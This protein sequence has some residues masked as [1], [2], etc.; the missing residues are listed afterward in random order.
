ME[1][2]RHSKRDQAESEDETLML[3]K[4]IEERKRMQSEV[5]RIHRQLMDASR[6]AGQAEV[7]T[8]VLH[9][10]GNV[11]NSVNVSVSVI[12]DRL[13]ALRIA[14]IAKAA[15]LL[16]EH[17]GDLGYFLTHDNKG[18]HLPKYLEGL[19]QDLKAEQA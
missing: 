6:E 19:G 14:N 1:G 15:A 17:D 8:S 5:E 12:G 11:L 3:E 2:V 4:E 18:R 13:R 7:A 16:Q 10:V 9:N